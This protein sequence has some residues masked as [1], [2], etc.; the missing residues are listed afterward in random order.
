MSQQIA[1]E[2]DAEILK[3][4]V[5]TPMIEWVAQFGSITVDEKGN[6]V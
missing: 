2:I 5:N 6:V 4:L 3:E 1:D